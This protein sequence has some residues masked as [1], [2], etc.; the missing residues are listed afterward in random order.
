[1]AWGGS[2]MIDGDDVWVVRRVGRLTH[3]VLGQNKK[4][5]SQNR[6]V[7]NHFTSSLLVKSKKKCPLKI[8]NLAKNQSFNLHPRIETLADRPET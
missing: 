8:R 2:R 4:N 1:M 7:V 5:L 6:I 3:V